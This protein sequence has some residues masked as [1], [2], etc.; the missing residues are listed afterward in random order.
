[1]ARTDWILRLNDVGTFR[2]N[3]LAIFCQIHDTDTE[4]DGVCLPDR[5]QFTLAPM[6]R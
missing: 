6:V 1:M 2:E 4:M 5:L 3:F